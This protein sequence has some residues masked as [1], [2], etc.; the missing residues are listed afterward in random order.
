MMSEGIPIRIQKILFPTDFTAASSAA[1]PYAA[2]VAR[3]FGS[4]IYA[5]H[6]I[7]PESYAHFPPEERDMVLDGL[8]R[9]AGE[10]VGALLAHSHF[11][12]IPCEMVLE[13]GEVLPG[14]SRLVERHDIDLIVTASHGK[15]GFHKLLTGSVAEEIARLASCPVL[16]IGPEIDIAPEAEVYLDRILFATDFSAESSR[17]VDY[18]Y[19]LARAYGAHLCFLHV[20]EAVWTEPL[21]TRVPAEE[22]FRSRLVEKGWPV[23]KEGI[24]PELLVR[25]GS[26]ETVT[27]ET[28]AE[29][30]IQLIVLSIRGTGHPDLAAHLPGPLAYNIVSHARCPV[31]VIRDDAK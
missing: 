2:A 21:A 8:S 16:L 19:A 24:E 18:A 23:S 6:I 25:N 10:R 26:R 12:G 30:D 31:V 7:Q 20:I 4:T 14:L 17:A 5:V 15:H 1:L 22:F 3:R 29:R 28:A 9:E 27:L 11:K 13:H